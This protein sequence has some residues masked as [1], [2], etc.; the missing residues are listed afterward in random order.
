[1]FP[2]WKALILPSAYSLDFIYSLTALLVLFLVWVFRFVL[3]LFH[4]REEPSLVWLTSFLWSDRSWTAAWVPQQA[5]VPAPLKG[6][7]DGVL[8]KSV[9][10][11]PPST[12][13]TNQRM[14]CISA[15]PCQMAAFWYSSLHCSSVLCGYGKISYWNSCLV[16]DIQAWPTYLGISSCKFQLN[17]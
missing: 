2:F 8:K 15:A 9:F 4:S 16:F 1:M 5:E 14:I 11:Q 10:S 7:S 6:A 13:N 17:P 3:F 12:I